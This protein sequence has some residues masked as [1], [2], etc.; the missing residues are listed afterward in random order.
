MKGMRIGYRRLSLAAAALVV[1]AVAGSSLAATAKPSVKSFTPLSAKVGATIS[2]TGKNFSGATSVKIDGHKASFSVKSATHITAKVPSGAKTGKISVTTKGGTAT[3]TKSLKVVAAT[4]VTT[5]PPVITT[6]GGGSG[7]LTANVSSAVVNS[8]GNTIVLTY[9]A[10]AAISDGDV[11]IIVPTG[12]SEPVTTSAAGCTTASAGTVTTAGYRIDDHLSLSAGSTTTI[13][14]GAT[15]GGSCAAGDGAVASANVGNQ[16]FVG[17]EQTTAGGAVGLLASS[18]TIAETSQTYAANGS[19]TLTTTTTSALAPGATGNT[20]VFVYTAAT[21]GTFGGILE[22]TVP[23]GWSTPSTSGGTTAGCVTTSTGLA[24]GGAGLITVSDLNLA[25]GA[26]VTITYGATSGSTGA[27]P[28]CTAAG[29][30][31]TPSPTSSTAYAFSALEESTANGGI[32]GDEL[33]A[34]TASPSI[35]V[36]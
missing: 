1:L 33:V 22:I 9:T 6:S 4:V 14:Y 18:P 35:T 19:G 8:S 31:K 10:S 27:S 26:T 29:T 17:E 23:T 25:A 30:V 24:A 20:I 16:K 32:G 2:I 5:T 34:L 3:S 28:A 12:W 13:T 21:G 7:S 15:S 11:V 36:T